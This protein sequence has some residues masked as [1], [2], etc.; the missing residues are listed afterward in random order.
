M[1]I[2]AT[3]MVMMM[4]MNSAIGNNL[5]FLRENSGFTQEQVASFLGINRSAYANYE[6][7]DRS[8]P[9]EVMESVA[10]LY[11]VD[12]SDLFE[13]DPSAIQAT[14]LCAFRAEDLDE[15][16]MRQVAVFKSVAMT[17]LKLNKL[18]GL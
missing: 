14:L 2:F 6:T 9:L 12:L 3:L 17:Y 13:T 15:E 7:G 16:D 10:E 11:G 18:L 4:V 5:K 1:A 8:A